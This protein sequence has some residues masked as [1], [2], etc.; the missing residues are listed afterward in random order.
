M[1]KKLTVINIWERNY[2]TLTATQMM[3][4]VVG[5]LK[6]ETVIWG[7]KDQQR[8]TCY[9]RKINVTILGIVSK[10]RF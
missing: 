9:F 2:G 6:P 1:V 3:V 8:G 4:D 10:F 5:L 7:M